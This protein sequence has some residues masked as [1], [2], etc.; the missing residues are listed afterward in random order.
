MINEA[1]LDIIKSFE[2]FSGNPYRC[3][4]GYPTVGY[5]SIYD[6]HNQRV[7]MDHEEITEMQ[8]QDLLRRDVAGSLGAVE[9]LT[10][11]YLE[12]LNENQ[13][14]AL[15]SLVYNIGSGNFR[16]SQI[17]SL[18]KRGEINAAGNLFWQW[19]RAGGRILKGLVRRRARETELYFS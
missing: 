18:I 11:P 6:L 19:R 3:P 13:K 14:G 9:R 10:Q 5:G 1:A 16:A 12:D 4:A 2:G 15:T 8:A 17:R 7:T